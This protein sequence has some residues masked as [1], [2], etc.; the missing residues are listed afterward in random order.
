MSWIFVALLAYLFLVIANLFDKFLIDN[1]LPSSK[2]YTF[3]AC[4]LGGLVFLA[5]PWFLQWPGFFWF[6][7][8]IFSGGIFVA[9]LLTLYESLRRG[10]ASRVLVLVGGL[11]P[12]FSVVFSILFF[13]EHYTFSQ[14]VGIVCLILGAIIIAFLPRK[15]N[16][17]S[18]V[19]NKLKIRQ[20]VKTNSLIFAITSAFFYS[21]Y[22]LIT[23]YAYS[24]Q[25][26]TSAFLWSRLGAVI[27]VL[28]FLINIKNRKE[29]LKIFKKPNKNN[30]FLVV[31]GQFFG[32]SGFV[33]QNYAIFL[34]S[35][36]LVNAAQGV[37]YALLLIISTVLAL[38]SP[39]LLKET[40]SWRIFLQKLFAVLVIG[41]G[42][43]F[44][45]I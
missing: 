13:K 37:Q 26:F 45:M 4:L 8:N 39:K 27:F 12:V 22:F 41:V 2:A 19:M 31:V 6:F 1:V 32:A 14:W 33:L 9:A 34:G 43:Y 7:I 11:T 24:A 38:I 21:V 3:I 28:F 23:K 42:L 10:E 5:A 40:F 35:V 44:I 15:R 17:L 16:W 25:S 18:R 29:I 20:G 30:K 36:A